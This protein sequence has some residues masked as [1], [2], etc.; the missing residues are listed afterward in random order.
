MTE[1]TIPTD[2]KESNVKES[3]KNEDSLSIRLNDLKESPY[4]KD[5]DGTV[6][7]EMV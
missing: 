4:R 1:N 6:R 2:C 7:A 3:P 5:R